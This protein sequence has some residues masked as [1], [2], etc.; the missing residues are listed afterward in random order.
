[1]EN[2]KTDK[3]KVFSFQDSTQLGAF[4]TSLQYKRFKCYACLVAKTLY[5]FGQFFEFQD[6][7]ELR[8]FAICRSCHEKISALSELEAA[9]AI[10]LCQR[11]VL[12]E[13]YPARRQDNPTEGVTSIWGEGE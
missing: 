10:F 6:F 2:N 9:M 1:M 8:K 3:E 11:R 12:W 13:I 7:A 4:L 5:E